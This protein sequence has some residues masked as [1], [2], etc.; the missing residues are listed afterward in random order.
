M[1]SNWFRKSARLSFYRLLPVAF[2]TFF[3]LT[4]MFYGNY[5]PGFPWV[6]PGYVWCCHEIFLQT[7]CL[8]GIYGLS[9]S[10]LLMA[11]LLGDAFLLYVALPARRR[12]KAA[13][14]GPVLIAFVI[15]AAI[16]LFGYWRLARNPTIYTDKRVR[17]IQSNIS[18]E[19]KNDSAFAY[20]NLKKLLRLSAHSK[21][22]DLVIWPEA[23]VPYLYNEDFTRLHNYLK[24]PLLADE[25]LLAGAVRKD[26][27]TGKIFNSVIFIDHTGKHVAHYDKAR[28]TPFGEYIPLRK[29]FPLFQSIAS[30]IGDF[31]VGSESNLIEI[32]GIKILLAICYE[33]IFPGKLGLFS[34]PDFS[35]TDIIV[36]ITNDGWF[37]FT[38]EP[39][40][41]L[42]ISR[43]RAIEAGVPL[44]RVANV[45]VSAV[46]DPCGRELSTV[47][48]GQDGVIEMSI[49]RSLHLPY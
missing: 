42:Q 14:W 30:D 29:Y 4:M 10:T 38:S 5:L 45:G 13:A 32:G 21:K 44:I 48:F 24:I 23:S 11:G 9:F 47:P 16:T 3:T 15:F 8:Y 33:V 41:H 18:Q 22:V 34:S 43:A 12:G 6:L 31:N 40:Q 19:Q 35:K 2:A 27:Q 39:A 37:G 49:P 20:S 1:L 46:F 25:Y 36:N 28:L 26:L 7:L 17:I